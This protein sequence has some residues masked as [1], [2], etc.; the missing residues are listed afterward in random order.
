MSVEVAVLDLP[1]QAAGS[2]QGP[3]RERLAELDRYAILDTPAEEQFDRMATLARVLFDTPMAA[4]P[5]VNHDRQ[6]FKAQ[7]GL[8]SQQTFREDSFCNY[9]MQN[10]GVFV[11]P[12]AQAGARFA[13]NPLVTGGPNIRI[14]CRR[15]AAQF[16]TA[17][18][19]PRCA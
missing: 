7:V 12:D 8:D 11:V 14:L 3:E 1:P 9:A 15:A 2:R 13:D 18:V 10:D 4:I 6:W 5:L 17:P 19:W 16:Q